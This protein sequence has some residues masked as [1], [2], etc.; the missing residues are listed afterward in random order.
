MLVEC[1]ERAMSHTGSKSV[2]IVGGVGCNNRLQGMM[3][4]MCRQRGG[5]VAGMDSRYCIDNGAMIGMAGI[6]E[7]Q[8]GGRTK[9]EESAVSQRFRTDQVEVVWRKKGCSWVHS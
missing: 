6:L 7:Y 2:L 8:F 9:I 4:D 5:T 1:T 3:G